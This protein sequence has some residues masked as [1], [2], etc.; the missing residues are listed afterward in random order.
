MPE[1]GDYVLTVGF[2]RS[3]SSYHSLVIRNIFGLRVSL[4]GHDATCP[5]QMNTIGVS[6]SGRQNRNL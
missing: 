1:V 6:F 3:I 2:E 4:F 5:C